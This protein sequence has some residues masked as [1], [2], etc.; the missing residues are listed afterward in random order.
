M[1]QRAFVC[2]SPIQYLDVD[3]GDG[4]VC[5]LT[6]FKEGHWALKMD[7]GKRQRK[8]CIDFPRLKFQ[9]V[10]CAEMGC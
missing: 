3:V 7:I 5:M 8:C 4:A 1:A 6:L 9:K 2:W 10:P